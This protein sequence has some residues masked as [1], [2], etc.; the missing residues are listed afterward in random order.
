MRKISLYFLSA[1]TPTRSPAFQL[2]RNG[3]NSTIGHFVRKKTGCIFLYTSSELNLVE[4][5][6]PECPALCVVPHLSQPDNHLEF[7]LFLKKFSS[8]LERNGQNFFLTNP[9]KYVI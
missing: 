8:N 4:S 1:G 7:N 5:L 6:L 2:A 9:R 3:K